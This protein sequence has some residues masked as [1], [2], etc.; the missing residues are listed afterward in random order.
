[1]ASPAL[2]AESSEIGKNVGNEVKT[3]ATGL[4][5]GVAALVGIPALAKRDLGQAVSL[6]GVLLIVGMFAFAPNETKAIIKGVASAIAG[7]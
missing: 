1:V 5:L 7:G 6:L 4:I 2:A 3:W